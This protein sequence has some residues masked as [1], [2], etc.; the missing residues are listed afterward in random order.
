MGNDL[1]KCVYCSCQSFDA[2]ETV[3]GNAVKGGLIGAGSS[4]LG[5]ALGIGIGAIATAATGGAAAPLVLTG[6]GSATGVAAGGGAAALGTTAAIV[7]N[8]HTCRCGHA[9]NYH[10]Y[11]TWKKNY[12]S[13]VKTLS[14]SYF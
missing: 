10:G 13:K 11:S 12:I 14:S 1:G 3:A 9:K 5:F 4:A 7:A 2:K 8:N 6:L